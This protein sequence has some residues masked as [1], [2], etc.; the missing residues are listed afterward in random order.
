MPQNRKHIT[1]KFRHLNLNL[2]Y[3]RTRNALANSG[4]IYQMP[5]NGK[6]IG[7]KSL[8]TGQLP[9]NAKDIDSVDI[10]QMP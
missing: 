10:E 7:K 2:R 4:D 5:Q 8:D 1:K 6:D 9:Q 3:R